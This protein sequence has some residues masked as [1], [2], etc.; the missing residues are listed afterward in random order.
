[1]E[2]GVVPAR[3]LIA[4]VDFVKGLIFPITKD[5]RELWDRLRAFQGVDA[6]W[7]FSSEQDDTRDDTTNR[8]PERR[9]GYCI[10]RKRR[11]I[12]MMLTRGEMP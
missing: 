10:I 8:D 9:E 4:E 3:W 12:A 1:M 5:K 7:S 2:D 11:P 6:L